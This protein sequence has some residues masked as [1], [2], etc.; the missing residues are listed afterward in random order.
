[1]GL[2]VGSGTATE[3]F[4]NLYLQ[5]WKEYFQLLTDTKLLLRL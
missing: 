4:Y 5:A 3:K 1:M 2:G